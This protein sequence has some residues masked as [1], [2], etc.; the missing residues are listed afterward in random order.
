MFLTIV[1]VLVTL[2]IAYII[3]PPLNQ[4]GEKKMIIVSS[5][6]LCLGAI[7]NIAIGLKKPIPSPLDFITFIFTPIRKFLLSLLQ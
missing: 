4:K 1:I 5:F 3:I 6:F 7:V 2:A